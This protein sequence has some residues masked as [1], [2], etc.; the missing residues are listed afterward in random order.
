MISLQTL[1][2]A[3][4]HGPVTLTL[5]LPP[6][7]TQAAGELR[8]ALSAARLGASFLGLR[9]HHEEKGFEHTVTVA[10]S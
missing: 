1:L 9:V 6:G 4:R 10:R 2:S 3:T 5:S 8:Q 7:A